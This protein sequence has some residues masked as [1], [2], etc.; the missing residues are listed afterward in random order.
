VDLLPHGAVGPVI[1]NGQVVRYAH[2]V[3]FPESYDMLLDGVPSGHLRRAP[4]EVSGHPAWRIGD[5]A[6]PLVQLADRR[7]NDYSDGYGYALGTE[8]WLDVVL[9][10]IRRALGRRG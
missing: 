5:A 9:L 7:W 8:R 4:D 6:G 10:D 1:R 2:P 3:A